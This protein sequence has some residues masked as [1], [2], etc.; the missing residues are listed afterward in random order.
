MTNAGIWQ[1]IVIGLWFVVSFTQVAQASV[2]NESGDR[3]P[4]LFSPK[5]KPAGVPAEYVLTHNGFFHPSCV[6]RVNSDEVVGR[7]LVIRGLDGRYHDRI[8]PCAH[9]RFSATGRMMLERNQGDA[10]SFV[11]SSR[12]E[13]NISKAAVAKEL[14]YDGYVAFFEYQGDIPAPASLNS[15]WV[16]PQVPR[17]I[18]EQ[19]FGIF[20]GIQAA[21]VILQPVL[22]FSGSSGHWTIIDENCCAAGNLI[23]SVPVSV[24][25]GD[26]ILGSVKIAGCDEDKVCSNWTVTAMDLT[27][28]KSTTINRQDPQGAAYLII[29]AALEAYS[30]TSCDM[31]PANGQVN[32]YN[33]T[34]TDGNGAIV[35][36]QYNLYILPRGANP[37]PDGFPI[38]CNYGGLNIGNNFSLVFGASPS[39]VKPNSE[40]PVN[41]VIPI[42]V[43][44]YMSGNWYDPTQGGQG[45]QLEMADNTMLAIWFTYAPDGSGQNWIYAQGSYDSTKSSVT[46]PAVLLTGAR[47]APNFRT[48]DVKNMPWGTLTF[49]FADCDTGTASWSSTLPGYGAGSMP[50]HRLTQIKGTVCP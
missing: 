9:P 32:F 40:I 1:G 36:K 31:W 20:S 45:F 19:A 37:R 47:F 34:L 50:I 12:S 22:Q 29:P 16:V 25:P 2:D 5:M 24:M 42:T 26:V 21:D 4:H 7:D 38:D 6:V 49:S 28:R 15:V 27:T 3:H 10:K 41:P 35:Q 8:A 13:R 17:T 11:E 44:G 14:A 43:D 30:V 46:L 18:G 48:G 39:A 23:A 33:N